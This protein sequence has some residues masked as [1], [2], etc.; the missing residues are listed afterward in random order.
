MFLIER[1]YVFLYISI[2]CVTLF[3]V[4]PLTTVAQTVDIPDANL[5][6]AIEEALG[7]TSKARDYGR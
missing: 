4:F 2:F 5:R 1:K 7:K 3:F 6:A